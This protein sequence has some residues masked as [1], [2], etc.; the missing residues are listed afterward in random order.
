MLF[1]FFAATCLALGLPALSLHAEAVRL[2]NSDQLGAYHGTEDTT[3]KST[4]AEDSFGGAATLEVGAAEKALVRFSMASLPAGTTVGHATLELTLEKSE[5][6]WSH[7]ELVVYPVA[8]ADAGWSAGK[9][10]GQ[11]ENGATCWNY[12]LYSETKNIQTGLPMHTPMAG[13]A[14]LGKVGVDYV[15]TPLARI[16]IPA[17]ANV[18]VTI[19][20][21]DPGVVQ[22]WLANP[23]ANAGLLLV[24]EGAGADARATFSSSKSVDEK[25]RPAL[26]LEGTSDAVTSSTPNA[27]A[28]TGS[29]IH[30]ELK[31]PGLISLNVYDAKGQVVRELLHAAERSAGPHDESWDGLDEAEQHAPAG[32]YSWKLLETQGLKAE[33]LMTLGLSVDYFNLWPGNHVGVTGLAVDDTGVYFGSGCSEARGFVMKMTPDGTRLWAENRN[34]FEEWQ[35]PHSIAVDGGRVFLMQENYDIACVSADK[36]DQEKMWSLVYDKSKP[37]DRPS[38]T[39]DD[40]GWVKMKLGQAG[41]TAAVDLAAGAGKLVMS[42]ENYGCIRWL[43]EANGAV[44]SEVKVNAPLGVAIDKDGRAL[45][46]SDGQVLAFG[47]SDMFG[48]TVI[49]ADKLT[50]PWRL[51]VNRANGE[52]WV[53]ERGTSQQV[54][55][56]SPDGKLLQTFGA[57]GGRP[58]QGLYDGQVGFR[59]INSIAAASDGSFWI[60]EAFAAPRRLAHFGAD[61]KLIREWYGPQMY[62]NRG[63]TDPDDPSIVWMDSMWGEVIQAKVDYA[64]KSWKVLATY[65]YMNPLQD[66]YHHEGGMWFVRH[67]KGHTYLAKE[68]EPNVFMVD[69]PGRRLVPMFKVGAAFYPGGNAGWQL[70]PELRPAQDPWP[71]QTSP[72]PSPPEPWSYT[73]WDKKGDGVVSLAD[74]VFG[75]ELYTFPHHSYVL[76]DLTYLS[77]VGVSWKDASNAWH[78]EGGPAYLHPTFS[79]AGA[80]GYDMK[81]AGNLPLQIPAWLG[82]IR[83]I[84][85]DADGNIFTAHNTTKSR[86]GKGP[87]GVGKTASGLGGNFV[88]KWGADGSLK[89]AVGHH[90][91]AA[92]AGPGE[93]RSL[94][95]MA[96]SVQGCIAVNDI[97]NSMVHVWDQDGLWV[98]RLLDHGLITTTIPQDAYI[99]CGENF[100]GYLFQNSQDGQVYFLGDSYNATPV[101]RITGWDQFQRQSGTLSVP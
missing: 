63:S 84:W 27:G 68:T 2:S 41:E 36:G 11:P 4:D 20:L 39:R 21:T 19:P 77:D 40:G 1:R 50:S 87:F 97:D 100:G 94:Y 52:I 8:A 49:S 42:Y 28:V 64:N 9:A 81:Q 67:A 7:G 78:R 57:L 29:T 59:K 32:Q 38:S 88:A 47:E 10:N 75:R 17:G 45:V 5:G 73:W 54:K 70:P 79:A 72:Q 26:L 24:A 95:R 83:C 89:W 18:Q 3:I 76:P 58:A 99:L 60:T 33:Y 98:G 22:A 53:A 91:A 65:A 74:M 15:A 31:T 66:R 71:G 69:E 48:S 43:N 85:Q 90:A 23:A 14:G 55:R 16:K 13:L 93:A 92:Q 51:S 86:A 44:L 35:G 6:D 61:G 12:L 62:A 96:G 37:K 80:P 82:P 56:F 46:I 34:W 30:Y 25:S 101:Y